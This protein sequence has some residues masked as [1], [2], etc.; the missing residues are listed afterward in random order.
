MPTFDT[1]RAIG[2][3]QGFASADGIGPNQGMF[4][5]RA[6]AATRIGI[7]SA[8]LLNP[9]FVVIDYHF[10]DLLFEIEHDSPRDSSLYRYAMPTLFKKTLY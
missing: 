7:L 10:N 9:V 5:F 2:N 4:E 3:N 1:H 6:P 8:S